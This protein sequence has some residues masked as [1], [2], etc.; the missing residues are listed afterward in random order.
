[1][2]KMLYIYYP[3][4]YPDGPSSPKTIV[5]CNCNLQISTDTIYD[6]TYYTKP[7]YKFQMTQM[8][9]H[10]AFIVVRGKKYYWSL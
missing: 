4:D 7:I 9:L 2:N 6:A 10:H 8:F 3:D 5:N 1:M